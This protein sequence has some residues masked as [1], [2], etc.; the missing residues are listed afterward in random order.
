MLEAFSVAT[1]DTH[2][3]QH[4]LPGIDAINESIQQQL[5]QLLEGRDFIAYGETFAYASRLHNLL[6]DIHTL[7]DVTGPDNAHHHLEQL[8]Q[9]CHIIMLRTDDADGAI[10]DALRRAVDNWL[11]MAVQLRRRGC[12]SRDWSGA[13]RCF[14]ENNHSGV[15]DTIIESSHELLT[16]DELQQLAWR[17]ENVARQAL[18]NTGDS[19]YNPD[20]AHACAALRSIGIALADIAL[21][22]KSV[23]LATPSPNTRQIADMVRRAIDFGQ[24]ERA[25]HWLQQP[26]WE[27]DADGKLSLLALLSTHSPDSPHPGTELLH[28]FYDCPGELTL[29]AFLDHATTAER[30]GAIDTIVDLIGDHDDMHEAVAMWLIL[31][32][33]QRA[34]H[35]LV[36]SEHELAESA[37]TTLLQWA[38]LFEANA[39]ALAAIL[40]YRVVINQLLRRNDD[41]SDRHAGHYLGKLGALDLAQPDYRRTATAA[42]YIEGLQ[43]RFGDRPAFW[44]VAGLSPD[45]ESSRRQP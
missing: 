39:E 44:A 31:G 16:R 24:F 35:R 3:Q 25:R 43:K 27:Q 1:R 12:D 7:A 11:A 4:H 36:N 45:I 20:L 18:K 42:A 26:A 14:F 2:V 30:D 21:V 9:T 19:V 32:D 8:L 17:F 40:C 15:F 22:E 41:N 34:A 28:R 29:V 38:S 6:Q 5:Q 37:A 23:L 10:R 33:Y 13:V